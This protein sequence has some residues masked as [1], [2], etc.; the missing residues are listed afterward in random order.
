[1]TIKRSRRAQ[2]GQALIEYA[3]L[4]IMVA[5]ITIAVIALAGNQVQA[6]VNKV[7]TCILHVSDYQAQVDN[8]CSQ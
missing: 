3:F 6:T 7:Q 1:M 5:T 4:F 2:R 8:Q